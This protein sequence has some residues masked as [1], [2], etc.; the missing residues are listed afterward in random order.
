[1][2]SHFQW[3]VWGGNFLGGFIGLFTGLTNLVIQQVAEP[4]CIEPCP[5]VMD[6]E[7]VDGLEVSFAK[8]FGNPRSGKRAKLHRARLDVRLGGFQAMACGAHYFQ[9]EGVLGTEQPFQTIDNSFRHSGTGAAG[10]NCDLQSA[11]SQDRGRYKCT[12]ARHIGDIDR[13]AASARLGIQT[14]MQSRIVGGRINQRRAIHIAMRIFA[15]QMMN[16]TVA[17]QFNN[18]RV[19]LGTDEDHLRTGF[20]QSGN[21]A[22]SY[23]AAADYEA[24]ASGEVEKY[25]EIC[26]FAGAILL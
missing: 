13:N 22:S 14:L 26:H 24:F 18:R 2:V 5:E 11:A 12:Q 9:R 15:F 3:L 4:K 21:L 7:F 17:Y 6:E 20:Q 19:D 10:R 23:L 25:G 1:M 16:A 8:K